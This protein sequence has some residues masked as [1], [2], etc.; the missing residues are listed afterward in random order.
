MVHISVL[1]MVKNEKKRLHVTLESIK[2][3]ADSLIMFDTG[4]EDNTIQITKDFCEKYSI[5]LRLKEGKFV[6]FSVSR[7]ISLDF[8]DTFEDVDYLLLLDTNDELRGGEHLRKFCE[9]HKDEDNH[10]GF[11]IC[12]EWW[13]GQYDKY[14]NMR[15]IKARKGWRYRGSVHE[16]L[17]DT[18]L[19]EGKEPEIMRLQD[20]TVIYQDRTQD[21]D[22]TG[23]RFT[24]DKELLLND[25]LNDPTEPRTVFYLAQT[26]SCLDQQEDALYY[27]KVR[28]TLEGFYEEKFQSFLRIGEILTEMK[29][30]WY[31]VMGYYM[32]AFEHIARVE[33]IIKIVEHYININQWH[34]AFAFVNI[35]CELTYPEHCI[36]FV[37]KMA[38]DYKRWHLLGRIG[39]YCNKMNEGKIGCL[40]A[41]E[42]MPNSEVDK[43]NLKFYLD[44]SDNKN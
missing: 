28:T 16:W 4:S 3:F 11:L 34:I 38:Y 41:L 6:N 37:D 7:N 31:D 21:D 22:K 19:P 10:T 18:S 29:H 23:K 9:K 8:A 40:R 14:Y 2:N 35:A 17:K 39:Y 30:S 12:Q 42:A 44:N 27:Y 43:N 32:R 1:M 25:H 26:C 5:P 33:P 20:K 36:L 13:S 24:R 15:L